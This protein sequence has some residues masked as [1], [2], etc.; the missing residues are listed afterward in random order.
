[1]DRIYAT[2]PSSLKSLFSPTLTTDSNKYKFKVLWCI[3]GGV[4]TLL[5]YTFTQVHWG[6]SNVIHRGG[7][8]FPM[9]FT[10]SSIEGTTEDDE[11]QDRK[12]YII[13][14]EIT[15]AKIT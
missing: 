1:M 2:H 14:E 7:Y 9:N 12:Y 8:G 13:R 4:L 3:A 6:K 5:E 10:I 11:Y 15:D